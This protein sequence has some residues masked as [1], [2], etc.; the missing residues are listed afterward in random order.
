MVGL[1]FVRANGQRI[2]TGGRVVKNVAGFDLSKC[3]IGAQGR[4]VWSR[5]F[6]SNA[7][8]RQM[9]LQLSSL[10]EAETVPRSCSNKDHHYA[11]LWELWREASAP[12]SLKVIGFS[13]HRGAV[14]RHAQVIA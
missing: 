12:E 7:F 10:E 1:E 13:G 11:N 5:R 2:R 6:R 8:E 9:T 4:L 3:F 14:L